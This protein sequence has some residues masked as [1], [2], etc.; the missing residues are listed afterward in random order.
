MVKQEVKRLHVLQVLLLCS[1][2]FSAGYFWAISTMDGKSYSIFSS[3]PVLDSPLFGG[4]S[5]KDLSK[6]E[7]LEAYVKELIEQTVGD[8]ITR[9]EDL[10]PQDLQIL[11][12]ESL[13][14]AL[15]PISKKAKNN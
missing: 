7:S 9:E 3:L 10:S 4:H 8:E 12:R 14:Y 13:L 1:A 15:T 5:K 11:F 6:R 2:C